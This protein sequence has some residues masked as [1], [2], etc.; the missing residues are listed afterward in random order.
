M[1]ER[2]KKKCGCGNGICRGDTSGRGRSCNIEYAGLFKQETGE[3][4][5]KI[6][7]DVFYDGKKHPYLQSMR[8][9][10]FWEILRFKGNVDTD[11]ISIKEEGVISQ[12]GW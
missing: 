10:K 8:V 1:K 5:G 9:R 7:N 4:P 11:R 3:N 2:P 6:K 12:T